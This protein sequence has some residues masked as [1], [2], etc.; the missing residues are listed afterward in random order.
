[1]LP[2]KKKPDL[3]AVLTG[4]CAYMDA[5]LQGGVHLDIRFVSLS[6]M[7]FSYFLERL[8]RGVCLW[9]GAIAQSPPESGTFFRLRVY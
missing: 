6:E 9:K 8:H 5:T 4:V 2:R 7:F 1:M 3:A